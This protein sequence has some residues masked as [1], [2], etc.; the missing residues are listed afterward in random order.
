M[1]SRKKIHGITWSLGIKGGF[2]EKVEFGFIVQALTPYC[3]IKI[4]ITKRR[5][6]IG[7]IMPAF[8]LG[9]VPS[10]LALFIGNFFVLIFGVLNIL[11]GGGDLL[12][13]QMILSHKP[14]GKKDQLYLDHPT[15]IGLALFER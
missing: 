15:K 10:I 6:L 8:L 14:S 7:S 9:V 1:I 12:V 3:T 4:P 2:K 13:S 5:Y 11:S